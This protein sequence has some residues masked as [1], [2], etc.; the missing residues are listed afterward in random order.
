M[1]LK[2]RHMGNSVGFEIS[3]IIDQEGAEF[4]EKSFRKIDFSE[5]KKLVLDFRKV[6]YIGSLGVKNL[7]IFYKKMTTNGGR[8][9]IENDTGI[10]RELLTITKMNDV[11]KCYDN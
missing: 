6:E 10:F 9:Y 11:I 1:E 2:V 5:F 8:L 3:G 4:L 7:L